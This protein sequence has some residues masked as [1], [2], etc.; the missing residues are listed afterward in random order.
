MALWRRQGWPLQAMG[1]ER[2]EELADL[3][4]TPP[5]GPG[6]KVFPGSIAAQRDG[7]CLRLVPQIKIDRSFR[8]V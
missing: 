5:V 2:W 7:P 4:S 3:A 8:S 6:K 1:Y